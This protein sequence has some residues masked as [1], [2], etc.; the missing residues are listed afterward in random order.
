MY[1]SFTINDQVVYKARGNY[2]PIKPGEFESGGRPVKNFQSSF[3]LNKSGRYEMRLRA[4]LVERFG[5]T[6]LD[7]NEIV[8]YVDVKE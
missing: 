5:E 4:W 6:N 2:F 3:R 1:F 7:D 8:Q